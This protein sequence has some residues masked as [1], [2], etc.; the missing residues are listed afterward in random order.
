MTDMF[1][2][3]QDASQGTAGPN[4]SSHASAIDGST[5]YN[6]ATMQSMLEALPKIQ[7]A[8]RRAATMRQVQQ[9]FQQQQV[10]AQ[11]N[12]QANYQ[13]AQMG[14]LYPTVQHYLKNYD[15]SGVVGALGNLYAGYQANQ[16]DNSADMQ[17]N[18]QLLQAMQQASGGYAGGGAPATDASAYG[19]GNFW[20]GQ[21]GGWG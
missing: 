8:Q 18:Q 6:A 2:F 14:G 7:Q 9:Q 16:M 4:D 19:S 12:P 13:P 5:G 17:R 11:R 3:A 15:S 10:N 21:G 1:N 20:A